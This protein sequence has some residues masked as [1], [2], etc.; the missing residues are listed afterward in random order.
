MRYILSILVFF[1]RLVRCVFGD[2]SPHLR[3]FL[4]Y[5]YGVVSVNAPVPSKEQLNVTLSS[6][7]LSSDIDV[8]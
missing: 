5:N 8:M 1:V 6:S 7:G 4:T 3:V 2:R